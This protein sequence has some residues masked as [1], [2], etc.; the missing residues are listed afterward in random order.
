[1][2]I[3]KIFF[4]ALS[5]ALVF[6]ACSKNEPEVSPI[7]ARGEA[8][9]FNPSIGTSVKA[10]I[11]TIGGLTKFK[12]TAFE[13]GKDN[14]YFTDLEVTKTGTGESAVWNTAST[15]YWPNTT[16]NFF[17][18]ANN[19]NDGTLK[20]GTVSINKDA[21]TITDITP[22]VKVAEQ[23]D[24]IIARAEGDK[25]HNEAAGVSLK[26]KHILSQ[27]EIQACCNNPE[28][29][30]EVYNVRLTA[31]VN[32]GAFTWPNAATTANGALDDLLPLS[33]WAT[34]EATTD[35]GTRTYSSASRR[36]NDPIILTATSKNAKEYQDLLNPGESNKD[37]KTNFMLVPYKATESNVWK[38]EVDQ[39]ISNRPAAKNK[40]LAR[41][42]FLVKIYSKKPGTAGEK[43]EDWNQIV[44]AAEDKAIYTAVGVPFNWEPGKKYVYKFEF[45]GDNS[46]AG[47]IDPDPTNP[48][49]DPTEP[50]DPVDPTDPDTPNPGDPTLGKPIK[51]TVEVQEW[52]DATMAPEVIKPNEPNKTK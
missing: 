7:Q 23:D 25:T 14:N 2:R 30:I 38:P 52:K 26:F 37:Q 4:L 11:T 10:N 21:Q 41:V 50:I 5:A 20:S 19:E 33:Q 6:G 3:N 35:E 16:L 34:T 29:K 45:L 1:M 43:T 47:N 13:T 40:N 27:I 51:F 18:Y 32:K 48:D 24:I 49:P 22:N 8:I 9:S 39:D 36:K 46:G 42:S 15:Y 17:A 31:N 28:Y 44:P 12:V